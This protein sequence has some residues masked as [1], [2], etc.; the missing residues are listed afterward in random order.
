[1]SWRALSFKDAL[2]S[3]CC[4]I[5]ALQDVHMLTTIFSNRFNNNMIKHLNITYITVEHLIQKPQAGSAT[6]QAPTPLVYLDTLVSV[7]IHPNSV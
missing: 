2:K 7:H 1:M 4:L 6:A 3:F 5:F